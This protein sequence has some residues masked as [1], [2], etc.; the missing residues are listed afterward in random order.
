MVSKKPSL[1]ELRQYLKVRSQA[2]LAE[3]IVELFR[4]MPAVKDYYLAKL[5][6]QAEGQVLEKYQKI[7]QDEFF[8]DRGLGKGRL[9]IARQAVNDYKRV[10]V[11]PAN[12][13][14]IMLFYVEQGIKFTAEYGDIDDP[15]YNS[16]ESMYKK[17]LAWIVKYG[18]KDVFKRRCR[19]IVMDTSEM[20]WGF[21]DVLTDLYEETFVQEE[22]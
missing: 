14:D 13:A 2:E 12:V 5:T 17:A 11:H 20:G 8:P 6:P 19:R 18:L 7:I 10:A 4:R 1:T 21:H 15:F 3:E 22:A 16:M 9:S